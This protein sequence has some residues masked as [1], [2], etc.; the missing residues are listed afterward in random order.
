M[1]VLMLFLQ[2]FITFAGI[3]SCDVAEYVSI[4]SIAATMS[5]SVKEMFDK[6]HVGGLRF[7]VVSLVEGL[8]G[9]LK[10]DVYCI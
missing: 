3:H 7:S 9:S 10:T 8:S 5:S 4:S 1:G 2:A 6:V